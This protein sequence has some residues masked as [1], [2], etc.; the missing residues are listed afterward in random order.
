MY[1]NIYIPE[2]YG[3]WFHEFGSVMENHQTKERYLIVDSTIEDI[4]NGE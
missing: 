1:Q 2:W 4:L 3:V